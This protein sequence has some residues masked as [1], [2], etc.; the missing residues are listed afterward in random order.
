MDVLI[1]QAEFLPR[2]RSLDGWMVW[3]YASETSNRASMRKAPVA[4]WCLARFCQA[5]NRRLHVH[6][7]RQTSPASEK[8]CTQVCAKAFPKCSK[9]ESLGS[10]SMAFKH[11]ER[12][13]NNRLLVA[14]QC[15]IAT[16]AIVN[17][18][19]TVYTRET[20]L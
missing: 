11:V 18:A 20:P 10:L 16:T 13:M 8:S 4:F 2:D 15:C 6:A 9:V 12:I 1:A 7:D 5:L 17:L 3:S 19:L 14:P